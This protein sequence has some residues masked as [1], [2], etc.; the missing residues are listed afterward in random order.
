MMNLK[1]LMMLFLGAAI[2]ASALEENFSKTDASGF[3]PGWEAQSVDWEVR[4]G[5]L[6]AKAGMEK[7][8]AFPTS[9]AAGA[10]VTA[11]V[12]VNVA[13]RTT[14]TG[15]A[16]AALTIRLDDKNYWQLGLCETPPE[17]GRRHFFELGEC[18]DGRW[19][20]Q[21]EGETR[22]TPVRLPG[23]GSWSFDHNYRLSLTLKPDGIVALISEESGDVRE[24]ISYK[25][26]RRAVTAGAPAL[27]VAGFAARFTDFRATTAQLLPPVAKAA[28]VFPKYDAAGSDA[29]RGDATG[30]FHAEKIRDRWWLVDPNGRAFYWVGTD[31]VSYHGHWCEKLGYAPYGRVA[32][33]KYG[34][35]T[36]W[37]A[38]TLR[39]LKA[40][41]FNTL[42]A[43]HSPSLRHQGLPHI[44]FLSLGS[45]FAGRDDIC[46]RT[47]WTGFPNVFSPDWARH[48]DLVA[49]RQCAPNAHDPW[50]LGY[51]FDNELEWLGKTWKPDGLFPEVWKKPAEH[52]SKQA[53]IALLQKETTI[54]KFNA[55][56]GT[57]FAGFAALAADMTPRPAHGE[58]GA[59]L[60]RAWARLVAEKY[61]ATCAAAIR[62]H[63]PNHMLF[64]CRFA[65]SAPEIWD[66]AGKY[67]DVVTVNIYPF[68]DVER[69]VPEKEYAKVRDWQ[70]KTGRPLAVTEWSFPALDTELPSRHGAG[71][72]VDTQEQRAKCFAHYQDFLFRLPFM[73]GSSYFMWLDEPALGISSTFP[74]DSNYGLINGNDE[75]YP[76]ITADAA[77]LNAEVYQRHRDGGFEPARLAEPVVPAAWNK[78]LKA[79]D[80]VPAQLKLTAGRLTL[81]G[82][83]DGHTWQLALD[84]KPIANLFPVLH[85]QSGEQNLWTHPHSARITSLRENALMTAIEMEFTFGGTQAARV[86]MRYWIP[87][88]GD[89]LASEGVSVV[90]TATQE[91]RLGAL[92][93]YCAPVVAGDP[94]KMVPLCDAPQYYQAL[95]GWADLAQN[96]AVGCWAPR[97]GKLTGFFW[98]DAPTA[99]HSDMREPADVVLKPGATWQASPEPLLWFAVPAASQTA[100]A[101][102]ARRAAREAGLQ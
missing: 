9:L 39:R 34:S 46:P 37:V 91:W 100:S 62:R 99:F 93:H 10:E 13:Q 6:H 43:G 2:T 15:W 61:F 48:C 5:A 71:M 86:T 79:D 32:Q 20:A 7:S 12:T 55:E 11:E 1:I 54:A 69:G 90:N 96:R 59:E 74:E 72:R 82:P 97:G 84:G 17:Q 85:Q 29:A 22:L 68:L 87:K 47:T 44:E 45:A 50:L 16:V 19:L 60:A 95:A 52:T 41:G 94:A 38:E 56:F 28:R 53:W 23:H 30:F 4:Q 64:G 70:Q 66:I 3:A 81:E 40:W 76:L 65:G 89:W 63:D 27:A 57:A 67:C 31:H 18:L 101:A 83:R 98:K 42:A 73:V 80:A 88:N 92:F 24:K 102:A 35:E 58:L 26:D 78:K 14:K 36:N 8:L 25:F 33:Q 51:F 75:P 21:G 77:K 49:R